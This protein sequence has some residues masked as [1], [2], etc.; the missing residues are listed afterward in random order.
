MSSE[1]VLLA[2]YNLTYCCGSNCCTKLY[3]ELQQ[4]SASISP[5]N[6]TTS[7]SKSL[8]AGLNYSS[9]GEVD[10][11]LLEPVKSELYQSKSRSC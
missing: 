9:N 11:I 6:E 1:K 10:K 7:T 4:R 2:R 8:I 5:I 3:L